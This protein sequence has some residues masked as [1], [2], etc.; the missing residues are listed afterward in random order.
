MDWQG[1]I[2][3]ASGRR[4]KQ[5]FITSQT[6]CHLLIGYLDTAHFRRPEPVCGILPF[7]AR[8]GKGPQV[9]TELESSTSFVGLFQRAWWHWC[10]IGAN[11]E[12]SSPPKKRWS[13]TRMVSGG[14]EEPG[15]NRELS[16]RSSEGLL[17]TLEIKLI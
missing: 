5:V 10:Q 3:V 2:L 4:K 11:Q 7:V 12:G 6:F 13:A 1:L 16:L 17:S 8:M 14:S 15:W 9:E